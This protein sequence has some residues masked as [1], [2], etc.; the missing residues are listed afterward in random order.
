[1]QALRLRLHVL[2]PLLRQGRLGGGQ[3]IS[4][5][6][7]AITTMPTGNAPKGVNLGVGVGASGRFA[8]WRGDDS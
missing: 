7:P 3:S 1:M 2:L 8:G 6:P 4:T 5:L